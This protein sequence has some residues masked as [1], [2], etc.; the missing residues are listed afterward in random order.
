MYAI[1]GVAPGAS[2]EAGERCD[3]TESKTRVEREPG[4]YKASCYREL[5][6]I[7]EN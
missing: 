1:S 7:A 3:N 4:D 5:Q 2:T 6:V